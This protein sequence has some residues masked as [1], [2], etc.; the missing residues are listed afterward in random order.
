MQASLLSF[1]RKRNLTSHVGVGRILATEADV[2]VCKTRIFSQHVHSHTR[3]TLL[4]SLDKQNW[5]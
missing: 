3:H 2:P 4:Q 1:R 5:T